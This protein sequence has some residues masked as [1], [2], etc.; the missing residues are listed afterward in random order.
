MHPFCVI[1]LPTGVFTLSSLVLCRPRG[2][3]TGGDD[4]S[5][6]GLGLGFGKPELVK[7]E[8]FHPGAF[9]SEEL[10]GNIA[11]SRIKTKCCVLQFLLIQRV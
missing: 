5:S 7:D 2:L 3:L 10:M 9:G 6:M 4:S 11:M 8:S 1:G